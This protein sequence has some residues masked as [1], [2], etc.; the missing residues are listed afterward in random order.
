MLELLVELRTSSRSRCSSSP[1]T[2]ASSPVAD[3][4]LVLDEGSVCERRARSA[5]VLTDPADDYTRRLLAA[6]PTLPDGALR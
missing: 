3:D 6:A 1:T 5:Q 2:S 4:V